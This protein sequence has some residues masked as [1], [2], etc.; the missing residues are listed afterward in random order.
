MTFLFGIIF[1]D[2]LVIIIII[3]SK[4][5]NYFPKEGELQYRLQKICCT[6]LARY[7]EWFLRT[8]VPEMVGQVTV[9]YYR[10]LLAIIIFQK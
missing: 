10:V 1:L 2:I 3:H 8:I 5:Q 9:E 7:R 6:I 4:S